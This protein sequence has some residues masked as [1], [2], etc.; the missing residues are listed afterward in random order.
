MLNQGHSRV[1]LVS[2]ELNT[3]LFADDVVLFAESPRLLQAELDTLEQYCNRWSLRVNV[4]KSKIMVF[5][6]GGKLKN[7]EKWYFQ[8]Q[9]MSI[10]TYYPYLGV[11]FSSVHSWTYNQK[12]RAERASKGVFLSLIHI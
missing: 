7:Y 1:S 12:I 4:N 11:V 10:S 2:R 9:E 8:G 3:L 5:R 6:N